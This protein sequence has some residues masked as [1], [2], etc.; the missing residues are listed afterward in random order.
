MVSSPYRV[1]QEENL[2]VSLVP[3]CLPKKTISQNV[4]DRAQQLFDD[5]KQNNNLAEVLSRDTDQFRI[6]AAKTCSRAY[7]PKWSTTIAT[8]RKMSIS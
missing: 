2:N 3:E 6:A 4:F 5:P 1:V 8:G 7:A